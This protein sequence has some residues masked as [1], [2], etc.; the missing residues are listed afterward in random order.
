MASRE[1]QCDEATYS[2]WRGQEKKGKG[3]KLGIEL[4]CRPV[5]SLRRE[6]VGT[7]RPAEQAAFT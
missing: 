2:E 3:L 6:K 1:Y 4:R 5:S 7:M